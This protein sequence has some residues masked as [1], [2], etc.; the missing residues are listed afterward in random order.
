MVFSQY[1][2]G[3]TG[4]SPKAGMWNV[5]SITGCFSP[6]QLGFRILVQQPFLSK[7]HFAKAQ[8]G[9]PKNYTTQIR[10]VCWTLRCYGSGDIHHTS[11][12]V[13]YLIVVPNQKIKFLHQKTVFIPP[14]S[15][16]NNIF[17]F[18]FV[19][20]LPA[21]CSPTKK[22]LEFHRQVFGGELGGPK[23][24]ALLGERWYVPKGACS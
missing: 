20:F 10:W 19:G 22:D 14:Y 16:N 11:A 2:N 12:L 6:S 1:W 23:G 5:L 8:T 17:F 24:P 18:R 15:K 9:P 21:I 4:Q 13:E 3:H 7:K